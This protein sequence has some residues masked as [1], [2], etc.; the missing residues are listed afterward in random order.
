MNLPRQI[1][2]VIFR[3]VG[4]GSAEFLGIGENAA[5]YR[6]HLLAIGI[7]ELGNSSVALGDPGATVEQFGQLLH[8]REIEL[9]EFCTHFAHLRKGRMPGCFGLAVTKPGQAGRN[10]QT[11]FGTNQP[12]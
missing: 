1:G 12:S 10:A 2:A 8:G 6:V 5:Y 11:R 4:I 9:D 7:H 3:A